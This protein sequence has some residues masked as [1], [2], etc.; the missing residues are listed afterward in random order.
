MKITS[1]IINNV[2]DLWHLNK[3]HFFTHRFYITEDS[4]KERQ[5]YTITIMYEC[6]NCNYRKKLI[7]FTCDN[8]P[9]W[10]GVWN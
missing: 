8:N 10:I 5:K 4:K 6:G 7:E 3:G 9:G 1:E 2:K